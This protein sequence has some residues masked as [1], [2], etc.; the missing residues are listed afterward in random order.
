VER[1]R[2]VTSR[3][4]RTDV[5][6]WRGRWKRR[7]L[8]ALTGLALIVA[9]T[10][11]VFALRGGDERL[12]KHEYEQEVRSAYAEVRTAFLRT[13]GASGSELAGH[14]AESQE[15][16]RTAADRLAGLKP[17]RPVLA[18]HRRLY[19]GMRAYADDLDELRDAADRGDESAVASFND[20]VA[21]NPA[22]VQI[23]EAAEEMKFEGYD[24]GRIAED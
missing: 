8:L 21:Q 18:E 4:I 16:L 14:V 6:L 13:R 20:R 1:S 5:G 3:S 11:L 15:A 7:P 22:V 10:S 19:E 23:A 9:V 24:L 2:R 17:P 12:S